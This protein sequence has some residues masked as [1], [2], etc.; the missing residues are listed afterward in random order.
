MFIQD[1]N[2]KEEIDPNMNYAFL[3]APQPNIYPSSRSVSDRGL[4]INCLSFATELPA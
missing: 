1:P 2:A 3:Y 4:F